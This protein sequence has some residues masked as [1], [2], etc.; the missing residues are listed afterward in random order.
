MSSCARAARS[1]ACAAGSRD[2]DAVAPAIFGIA[3]T[4]EVSAVLELVEQQH[5]VLGVHAQRLDELLLRGSVVI[6][7]VA[8]RHEQA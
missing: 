6:G 5:D 4:N 2:V 8:Q 7:E 3:A 1:S